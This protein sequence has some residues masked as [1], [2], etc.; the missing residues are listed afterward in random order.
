V[1][2]SKSH[3]RDY[4]QDVS[5]VMEEQG[6]WRLIASKAMG[7]KMKNYKCKKTIKE[8]SSPIPLRVFRD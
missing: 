2:E 3:K 8:V 5:E 7:V 1:V 4:L 6:A